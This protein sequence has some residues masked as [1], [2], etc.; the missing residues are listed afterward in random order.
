MLDPQQRLTRPIL[1]DSFHAERGVVRRAFARDVDK[2][3]AVQLQPHPMLKGGLEQVGHVVRDTKLLAKPWT[4]APQLI[5]VVKRP[6]SLSAV[7]FTKVK[8]ADRKAPPREARVRLKAELASLRD[9]GRQPFPMPS[10]LRYRVEARPRP[11]TVKGAAG[12][13]G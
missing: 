9:E 8:A 11:R 5:R 3:R 6:F 12:G 7:S 10:K 1:G 2:A 13:E 4:N